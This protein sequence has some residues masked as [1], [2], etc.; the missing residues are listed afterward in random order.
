MGGEISPNYM[1]YLWTTV[2][3]TMPTRCAGEDSRLSDCP[4]IPRTGQPFPYPFGAYILSL[5]STLR[6]VRFM[7]RSSVNFNAEADLPLIFSQ[8]N[9]ESDTTTLDLSI[10]NFCSTTHAFDRVQS[11]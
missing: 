1:H 8:A 11:N 6:V 2:A 10:C 5:T 7:K 4:E 3:S 9:I